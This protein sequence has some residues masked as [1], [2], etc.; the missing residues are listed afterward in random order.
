GRPALDAGDGRRGRTSLRA[1]MAG[2]R[3]L[4]VVL[5]KPSKYG[6][7]GRVER[8]T[9]GF[10]PNATLPYLA[11]LTP[12]EIGGCPIEVHAIDEYVETDLN[13]LRLLE[14]DPC[15]VTLLALV[16]VQSHQLHRSLDLAA[17]ALR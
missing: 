17:Y 11:S 9:R 16:G 5:V 10:M 7:D 6:L 14:R 15:R 3:P 13:Y 12:P 8:F 2:A 4:R 1:G